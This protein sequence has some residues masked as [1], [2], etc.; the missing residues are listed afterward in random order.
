VKTTR[1]LE[2]LYLHRRGEEVAHLPGPLSDSRLAEGVD[3]EALAVGWRAERSLAVPDWIASA[4][5][6]LERGFLLLVDYVRGCSPDTLLGYSE[7]ATTTRWFARPGT[8]DITSH[9]DLDQVRRAAA[10]CG[11]V[12]C[13]CVDQ[14]YFLTSLGI[15]ERLSAA[16]DKGSLARR[17]GA[18]ML[19]LPGGLG[20]TM[21]VIG[22]ASR[23]DGAGLR[24]FSQ[25][26]VT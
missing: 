11:L 5:A 14:T 23:V 19:I 24:G 4:A 3:A 26:R 18:K 2:E 20:S 1:G 9:V 21:K 6:S 10:A 16:P 25:G 13:G 8:R 12:E 7:H 15:V 17:L 22:F